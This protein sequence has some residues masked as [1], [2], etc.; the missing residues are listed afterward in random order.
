MSQENV[1]ATRASFERFAGGDFSE[2]ADLPG[3]YE[4]VTAPEIPDAGTYRGGEARTW[5]NTW[6]ESF[7]S[8]TF[9]LV[10][11]FD[12]GDR[13]MVEL[14]Q[15]GTPKSGSGPSVTVRTWWITTWSEGTP[16]RGELFLSRRHAFEAAG[17]SE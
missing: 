5:M 15:R 2:I 17:L 13:V 14:V 12:A 3:G 7:D 10:E 9:E 16:T 1:E 4:I 11:I 6:V 8:L